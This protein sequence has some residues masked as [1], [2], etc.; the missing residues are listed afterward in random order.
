MYRIAVAVALLAGAS[1]LASCGSASSTTEPTTSPSSTI[2]PTS[3]TDTTAATTTS[4]AGSTSPTSTP[5]SATSATSAPGAAISAEDAQAVRDLAFKFWAAYNAYDPDTAVSYL[6]ESYRTAKEQ[7][8]RDEIGRIKS[9]GVQLGM[10]EKT[11]PA[12]TG[13]DQ[14]EMSLNMKEPIGTRTILMKF[15]KQGDAWIIIYSEEA[16]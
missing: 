1:L 4:T 14:A 2:A 6:D 16:K 9:F 10:S 13:P 12:L 5:T 7:T 11:A 15:A 3:T 8:I